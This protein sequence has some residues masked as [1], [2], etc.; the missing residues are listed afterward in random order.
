MLPKRLFYYCS[1]PVLLIL[2]MI[3]IYQPSFQAPFQFDDNLTIIENPSIKSLQN[4]P[5]IWIF[6][7]S[8]FLTYLSF[9]FNYYFN[10]IDTPGYH[11]V[12]FILHMLVSLCVYLFVRGTV[13]RSLLKDRPNEDIEQF[14]LVALGIFLCHPVQTQA[15]TYIS[16]RST[17]LAALFYVLTVIFY[18][19]WRQKK[20]GWYYVLALMAAGIGI[21]TK[22][23]FI[24]LPFALMLCE[25]FFLDARRAGAKKI[26]LYLAP[27][28][29]I[30]AAIPFLL[31]AWKYKAFD[32][33]FLLNVTRETEHISRGE[34]LLTQFNVVLTYIRLVFLPIGQ[35]LD[36]DFPLAKGFFDWPTPLS[37]LALVC[38]FTV[39]IRKFRYNRLLS[40]CI[41]WFFLTLSLESSVFPI[42]DV[43]FEHRLYLPMVGIVC[44][45]PVM[46]K[47]VLGR[48][49][50]AYGVCFIFILLSVLTYQRNLLWGDHVVFL[51][52]I[53]KKSPRKARV[54]NN[55]AIAYE[56][57]G[58]P[59]KAT[60]EYKKAIALKSQ[61]A[62]PHNNLGNIYAAQGRIQEAMEHFEK[63]MTI[64]PKYPA[65]VYNMGNVYYQKQDLKTAEE[66][67]RWALSLN[68]NFVPALVG[69]ASIYLKE[70]DIVR[71]RYFISEA[72]R[73]NPEYAQAYYT[74]GDIYLS[75][76]DYPMAVSAYKDAFYI[77]RGL[78]SAVNNIGNIRDMQGRYEIAI[79][80]YETAIAYDPTFA[81]AYFN[82]GNT[83]EKT[84]QSYRA[85]KMLEQALQLYEAQ[86]DQGMAAKVK[87]RLQQLNK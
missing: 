22:P 77:N 65:P 73:L 11:A 19:G 16:Q 44:L 3:L 71:S 61:Y 20:G 51:Q 55:L 78:V 54:H 27:F 70:G 83:L 62:H 18:I 8:R 5:W 29:L 10:G 13:Y 39:A 30:V 26:L 63:A 59:E 31:I 81:N 84:G 42:A 74:L 56:E 23:N 67:Y 43:I 80:A 47:N 15:V 6:D 14:S 68:P 69:L 72:L 17:L 76:R 87:E 33:H 60:Q 35:N 37:F 7:P 32:P 82:L 50:F 9:A 49:F 1:I 45:L 4:I 66:Y 79:R 38:L 48:R 52:D 41:F 64:D 53:V 58:D 28:F 25:I 21:F 46:L 12:N 36:Y 57:K 2:W 75:Q 85:V 86:N 40:F 24:T 34:Y